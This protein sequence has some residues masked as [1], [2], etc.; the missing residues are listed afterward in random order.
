M[1][2][3]VS[4][5]AADADMTAVAAGSRSEFPKTNNGRGVALQPMHRALFGSDLRLTS[6]LFLGVVGFV[7]LICCANVAN[8]LLARATVRDAR[9]RRSARRSARGRGASS[10][11][12]SPRAW[13]SSAI[14]GVLG[15]WVARPIL[16][17]AQ[18]FIPAGLLP[19]A[20][21]LTFDARVVAFCAAAALVVGLLF[22]LVPAWQ[23]TEFSSAQVSAPT[24]AARR[25]A[26]ESCAICSSRGRSRPRCCCSSAPDCCSAR[27]WRSSASIADTVP[28]AC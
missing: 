9:A 6:M 23:A 24:A 18:P 20:V 1:K 8:L 17:A 11:S 16:N 3:G 19:A 22:G 12:C 15:V 26:A 25:A 13:C 10:A 2:P 21:T 5:D 4:I 7:L 27:S 14:G 28:K